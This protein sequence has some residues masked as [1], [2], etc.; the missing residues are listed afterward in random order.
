MIK[1]PNLVFLV[2]QPSKVST[3][4]NRTILPE[5]STEVFA[6]IDE[7]SRQVSWLFSPLFAKSELPVLFYT[8]IRQVLERALT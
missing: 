1:K 2:V 6:R 5:M 4:Q 3:E 8:N 7:F